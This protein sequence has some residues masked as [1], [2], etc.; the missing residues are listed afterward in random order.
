MPTGLGSRL[1]MLSRMLPLRAALLPQS[2][3]A[4]V[5]AKLLVNSASSEH[6]ADV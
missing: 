3:H 4:R 2:V 5:Q 1:C 6:Q